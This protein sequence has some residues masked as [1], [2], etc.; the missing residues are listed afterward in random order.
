M[1]LSTS[2]RIPKCYVATADTNEWKS[3]QTRVIVDSENY[4][5]TRKL[6]F[7]N[8]LGKYSPDSEV[9][10]RRLRNYY[11]STRKLFC[12]DSEIILRRLGYYS[13]PTRKLFPGEWPSERLLRNFLREFLET[14]ERLLR[15]FWDWETSERVLRDFWVKSEWLLIEFWETSERALREFWR[16]FWDTSERDMRDFW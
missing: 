11:T 16:D 4:S 2:Y 7:Y 15:E 8:C 3:S 9:F 12:A 5:P 10:L 14:S 1:A 13:V 6:C